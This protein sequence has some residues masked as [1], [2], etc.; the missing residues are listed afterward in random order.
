MMSMPPAVCSQGNRVKQAKFDGPWG[1]RIP[2]RLPSAAV[3]ET[4][5]G[6]PFATMPS[7]CT[8]LFSSG[9]VIHVRERRQLRAGARCAEPPC[10]DDEPTTVYCIRMPRLREF[11]PASGL[12][13][14]RC[15][16]E[17]LHHRTWDDGNTRRGAGFPIR[18][19]TEICTKSPY[20]AGIVQQQQQHCFAPTAA[21]LISAL[22]DLDL[23]LA[24]VP[25]LRS[26]PSRNRPAAPQQPAESRPYT[27]VRAW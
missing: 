23:T 2:H 12:Q 3:S 14:V 21:S 7:E 16:S 8:T 27:V 20:Y 11:L 6:L 17:S 10:A 5:Q 1:V 9:G 22:L 15:K 19:P 24:L 18:L 4:A 13:S 26:L 25:F